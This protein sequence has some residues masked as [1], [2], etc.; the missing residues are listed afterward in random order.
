M[1]EIRTAA[2]TGKGAAQ[3]Q[4]ARFYL[5]LLLALPVS[6]AE[7]TFFTPSGSPYTWPVP[8]QCSSASATVRGAGGGGGAQTGMNGGAGASVTVTFSVVPSSPIVQAF[9]GGGGTSSATQG[10][11]GSGG[12]ASAVT[13]SGVL[14][15]AAAGGGG[16]CSDGGS[17][18]LPSYA[19]YTSG[20]SGGRPVNFQATC[21]GGGGSAL[22]SSGGSGGYSGGASGT[23]PGNS[24]GTAAGGNAFSF[25]SNLAPPVS[26]WSVGGV[27]SCGG[28]YFGGG[29]GGGGYYGGGGGGRYSA[30][31]HGAPGGGGSS[32]HNNGMVQSSS[33]GLGASG[34]SSA[35]KGDD[36]SVSLRC[37]L[38]AAGY[39]PDSAGD[40]CLSCEPVRRRPLYLVPK[41]S[42][43]LTQSSLSSLPS[44]PCAGHI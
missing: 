44:P 12:S 37:S 20:T 22:S 18:T 23:G 13:R 7:Q 32:W 16:G 3:Q 5:A 6:L 21:T 30:S 19:C 41:R 28:A 29:G 43:L 14:M 9:V 17:G 2:H 10:C 15:A 38:C 39:Y 8:V 4:H 42:A 40:V 1:P 36:G 11:C 35:M 26:G 31:Y 25:T 33:Y 24:P 34:G 27:G